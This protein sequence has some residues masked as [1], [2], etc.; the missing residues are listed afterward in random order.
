MLVDESNPEQICNAEDTDEDDDEFAE[1]LSLRLTI[2]KTGDAQLKIDRPKGEVLLV[3][4]EE[5]ALLG[6]VGIYVAE[7]VTGVYTERK[8]GERAAWAGFVSWVS[9][10]NEFSNRN[11][12]ELTKE[13]KAYILILTTTRLVLKNSTQYPIP[14][15]WA[16]TTFLYMLNFIFITVPFRSALIHPSSSLARSFSIAEFVLALTLCTIAV[17]SR[18]GNRP[19]VQEIHD[20]M[21]PSKEPL[22]SLFSILTFSWVDPIVWKGY[23]KTFELEDVWALRADDVAASV[24]ST[25]RQTKFVISPRFEY[26]NLG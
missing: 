26:N 3:L 4:L 9:S 24:L 8:H 25:Y 21:E 2:S 20:G 18:W 11:L 1:H 14:Q 16:H 19:V 13:L 6:L 5:L 23:W 10:L 22:A 7:L 15:L 17:S 12:D